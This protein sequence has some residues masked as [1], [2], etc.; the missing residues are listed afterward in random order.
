MSSSEKID[1]SMEFAAGVYL[2]EAQN[3]KPSSPLHIVYYTVYLCT[4]G[5]GGGELN[6]REKK[7]GATGENTDHKAWLKIPT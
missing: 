3:P 5:R 7:R 4:Q 1:L 6:Q 2:S